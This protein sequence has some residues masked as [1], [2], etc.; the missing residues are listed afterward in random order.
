M[1]DLGEKQPGDGRRNVVAPARI[2]AFEILTRVES[3]AYASILLAQDEK[4]DPR[5]RSLDYELVMG[6][7]R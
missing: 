7:L 6:V 1:K 5:D 4:L 3:G 2:A